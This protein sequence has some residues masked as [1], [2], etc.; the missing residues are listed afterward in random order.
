VYTPTTTPDDEAPGWIDRD[1]AAF[2]AAWF[3]FAASVLQDL[4][5]RAQED[6]EPSRVQIWPEHF[7]MSV[8]IGSEAA[9]RRAGFGCS[10][11]DDEHPMPYAYVT[12]WG[13]A[14][15]D[16]YWTEPHFRGARIGWDAIAAL[17]DQRG[18]VLAFFCQGRDLLRSIRRK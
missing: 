2:Y 5:A 10:P 3:G 16:P 4:R 17:P 11:G 6:E 1:G 9:G 18:A 8:E 14:P 13:Q 12:P 7:D 15:E